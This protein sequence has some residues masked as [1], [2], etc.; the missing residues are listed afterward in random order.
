MAKA[1]KRTTKKRKSTKRKAVKK[2]VE[3]V[4]E[5]EEQAQLGEG[6]ATSTAT[7]VETRET[8]M[9]TIETGEGKKSEEETEE[10]STHAKYERIKQGNL[11]LTDLQKL[12]AVRSKSRIWFSEFSK[13]VSARAA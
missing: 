7:A 6:T 12:T 13:S 8:E 10:E 11:Y 1:V 4:A 3:V 9:D 2:A 5:L